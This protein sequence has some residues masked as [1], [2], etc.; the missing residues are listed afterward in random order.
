MTAMHPDP[1]HATIDALFADAAGR[2]APGCVLGV[3]REGEPSWMRAYGLASLELGVPLQTDSRLRIAS[4]SKQF[5]VAAALLLERQGLLSQQDDIRQHLPELPELPQVVRVGHL[6]R[7]TSG[8]PDV[9]ELLRLGGVG[10]DQRVDRGQLLQ[11]LQRNRHLNFEPGSRF[12]YCNSGFALLGLITERL[13]G[14]SLD[15]QLREAFFEPLGMTA[16]SMAVESDQPLAGLAT[17]YLNAA[18][19]EWRRAQHGFEHGGE[20]GLVSSVED[21][22]R[23]AGHLLRPVDGVADLGRELARLLPLNAGGHSPYAHGLE[24]GRLDELSTLGHGGLWP[25][26][27]T[28]FLLLPEARMAVA[29]ISNDAGL[30]PY[31]QAR[32][33][34]RL[35]L[36]RPTPPQRAETAQALVGEWLDAQAGELLSL[37]LNSQGQLMAQQ[38]GASFE[39]QQQADGRWLPLR[40]AYEFEIA[41][42]PLDE[43]GRLCLQLGAGREARLQR[44]AQRP[45]LPAGLEGEFRNA[46]AGLRWQIQGSQLQVEGPLH[47]PAQAWTLRGLGEDLVELQSPGYWMQGS[48]LLRLQRDAAGRI[49]AFSLDSARIKGLLFQRCG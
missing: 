38:W 30:N 48:Q 43:Q 11:A 44:L 16:T 12:L 36:A 5:T 25:G 41:A 40:G 15:A 9:L 13:S 39:L 45:A 6:M 8:L 34:A 3:W 21:L 49:G 28:E 46:D 42:T 37:S 23:W 33:V 20:G 35:L 47:K 14:R 17:P 4:V 26:F 7:N 24:H 10:L 32:E 19:G 22:L 31:K 29:L 18:P 2:P 1:L 27:R